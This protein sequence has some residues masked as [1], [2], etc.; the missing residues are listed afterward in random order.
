MSELALLGALTGLQTVGSIER[1]QAG[2]QEARFRA[3]MLE[4]DARRAERQ[5]VAD[6]GAVTEEGQRQVARQR[7]RLAR[8]GVIL[9]GSPVLQLGETAA[10]AARLARE[11]RT[12]ATVRA[13]LE[14]QRAAGALDRGRRSGFRGLLSAGE[15]LLRARPTFG[16]N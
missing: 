2:E 10:D 12:D 9:A 14:R 3:D 6:A 5:G 13:D 7:A 11:A 8:A 15:T 16:R 4:Q 1:G